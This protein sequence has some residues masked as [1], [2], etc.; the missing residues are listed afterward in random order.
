MMRQKFNAIRWL[1]ITA[2]F[3]WFFFPENGYAQNIG[4]KQRTN[5]NHYSKEYPLTLDFET[6]T[7]PPADWTIHNLTSGETSWQQ[8]QENHT[9]E[10]QYAAVH[11]YFSG[12]SDGWFVSPQITLPNEGNFLLSFWSLNI[13]ADFYLD[14]RNSV[15]IST[16]SA[17]PQSGDFV[18]LWSPATVTNQWVQTILNLE[19][20]A[21]QNVYLAFRYEG[22]FAHAWCIDDIS[23]GADINTSPVINTNI[24][25]VNHSMIPDITVER[26]L[27][28]NNTGFEDLI[29]S[30]DWSYEGTT[31]NWLEISPTTATIPGGTNTNLQLTFNSTGL[32][33][34]LYHASI[35]IT[36]NDPENPTLIIPVVLNVIDGGFVS[37]NIIFNDYTFPT[38]I[39]AD[40]QFVS[41]QL[42]G[43]EGSFFWKEGQGIINITGEAMGVS[44]N[45]TVGGNFLNPE[46]N[47][48]LSAGR[49]DYQTGEWTFLGINPYYPNAEGEG[50]NI[51]YGITD[52]GNTLVGMQYVSGWSVKAFKWT[53]GVGYQMIGE[54]INL[55]S[56]ANGIS[57]DGSVIFGWAETEMLSRTPVIWYNN[58][59]IYIDSLLGGEAF[60]AS[61]NGEF[62]TGTCGAQGFI[63]SPTDG[64]TL[65]DN[66]L[67][68]GEMSPLCILNDGT[69][70]GY[71]N[72]SW[73][74]FPDTRRAFVRDTE[75]MMYS[76]NE[77][78]QGR[79]MSNAF[80]WTFFAISAITPD[81]NVFVGSATSPEG[82]F[83]TVM[84][85]FDS[86]TPTISILPESLSQTLNSGEQATQEIAIANTGTGFLYYQAN[87]QYL[88]K[89]IKDSKTTPQGSRNSISKIKPGQANKKMKASQPETNKDGI[90]IHYDGNNYG[91]AVGPNAGGV[92]YGATRFTSVIT[93]P[94]TG[95]E[96]ESLDVFILNQPLSLKLIIWDEGTT[97]NPGQIIHEQQVEAVPNSWNTIVLDHPI[98]IDG[99]D[100]WVGFECSHDAGI[101]SLGVDGGPAHP[102]GGWLSQDAITWEKFT[103][104][105]IDANWNTRIKVKYAGINWLT[106]DPAEGAIG[107]ESSI[108]ASVNFN[109]NGMAGGIYT[110]NIIFNSND[111]QGNQI[112]IPVSF[113]VNSVYY[114]L[115]FNIKNEEGQ[116]IEDAIIT[117]FGI[118]YPAGDYQFDLEPGTYA[119]TIARE[120][121]FPVTGELT[122]ANENQTIDIIMEIDDTATPTIDDNTSINVYP[123]PASDYLTVNAPEGIY[124]LRII[125]AKGATVLQQKSINPNDQIDIKSLNNGE[126]LLQLIS[127]K[128]S[129][130]KQIQIIR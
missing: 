47:G 72:E 25:A 80:N 68:S 21:G 66:T 5:T 45:G 74:P 33:F 62:V 107:E 63:W 69:V 96:F 124:N 40:G 70:F 104:F 7:F 64:I 46:L 109:A 19:A 35:T 9:P 10:G 14:G 15:L 61:P 73:P 4:L 110:A 108:D 38:G 41:G 8:I 54:N 48:L 39:S 76:F 34:G 22:T 6:G 122:M 130:T 81:A 103:D 36:S 65:F 20:Y 86:S 49:W 77:Y 113:E 30:V 13:D 37:Q 93:S 90:V 92:F 50:Y 42:M 123:N 87:I 31:Q 85:D 99:S 78:A 3:F 120:S 28:V 60:G 59:I 95:Y 111:Y 98:V 126:Y 16:S 27:L 91:N 52:D 100:I 84:I 71:N 17:D 94:Y 23:V 32:N 75:G 102:E 57:P 121:Y 51:A 18:E 2:M 97:T 44:L 117:L 106:I 43:G 118:P 55:N 53:E 29:I 119:Y 83:V 127:P 58:E 12:Q 115:V 56:R 105:G 116:A 26:N 128:G 129:I 82:N 1:F 11:T 114:S 79:G 88:D 125:D 89:N 112:T 101:Y 24:T 67:N